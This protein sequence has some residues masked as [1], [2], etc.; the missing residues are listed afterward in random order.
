MGEI[1]VG[2]SGWRYTSWRGDFYPRG[3]VQRRE[4]E[5]LASRMSS[6]E[7]NGSFYS[8]Q[9]PSTYAR[10]VAETPDDFVVA[11]KGSR[12]ITHLKQLRDVEVPLANFLASGLLALGPKLGPLLWQLPPTL[13]YD[14][15]VARAFFGLLPRTTYEL[16]H[17]AKLHDDRLAPD[18]VVLK[19]LVR[20]PVRHALE[21]RHES[22]LTEPALELLRAYDV[23]LVVADSP[24]RWP[25]SEERTSSLRYVRLHGHSELYASGYS[26]RSLDT[27]ATRSRLWAAEGDD[28]F[29][30]FDNDARGRA[31]HDAVGLLQRL[32]PVGVEADSA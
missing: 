26:S 10:I 3:L 25:Y 27:W 8:L 2:T 5:H 21:V 16:A 22:W 7:L 32:A 1:R 11:V 18:Q 13:A 29:V 15:L 20:R 30:Y 24:G 14:E 6:V 23:G 31:P 19:P 12:Y 4:L 28:V 9:R 17:L